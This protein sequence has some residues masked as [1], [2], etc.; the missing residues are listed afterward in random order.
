MK[1]FLANE[2]I[3]LAKNGVVDPEDIMI[4]FLIKMVNLPVKA[5]L[6]DQIEYCVDYSILSKEYKAADL[7]TLLKI[8]PKDK[9]IMFVK[10]LRHFGFYDTHLSNPDDGSYEA[11]LCTMTRT[12][13][14]WLVTD[15][16]PIEVFNNNL[17][18]MGGIYDKFISKSN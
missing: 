7:I 8:G 3:D 10:I 6:L 5:N 12:V 14:T 1:D 4:G 9:F 11:E 18:S 17:V 13:L 2:I 15:G 16:L